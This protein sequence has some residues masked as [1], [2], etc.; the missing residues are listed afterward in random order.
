MAFDYKKEFK[1]IYKPGKK[2]SLIEIP[3]LSYIAVRGKG[4]P[5]VEN[6][7]Y[8]QSIQLLYPIIFTIKMSKM[9][10]VKLDNYF[11]FVVPPLEGLWWTSDYTDFDYSNK[12]YFNFISMIRL[13]DFVSPE[14]FNWAV[15]EAKIKKEMDFNRVEYFSYDEG[16]CVQAMHVGSYDDEPETIS[17]L[18]KFIEDDYCF[19]L[20]NQRFHHEIYLSDPR[21]CKVENLK[22]VVRIPI[23]KV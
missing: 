14:I 10:D 21:R 22:T 11:D 4:N 9:T 12:D 17:K 1:D 2:P 15:D 8:K 7:E 6:S 23:R 19:D 18:S 13:P 20:S 5:N 3:K 16:L